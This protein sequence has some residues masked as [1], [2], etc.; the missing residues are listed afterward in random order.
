MRHESAQYQKNEALNLYPTT[1]PILNKKHILCRLE[2]RVARDILKLYPKA[3][4]GATEHSFLAQHAIISRHLAY[5]LSRDSLLQSI[6]P[7]HF[8]SIQQESVI[9]GSLC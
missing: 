8:M 6:W 5:S 1:N 7:C 3:V 9:F 2:T 4:I